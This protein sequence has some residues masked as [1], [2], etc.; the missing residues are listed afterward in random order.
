MIA[1]AQR[2]DFVRAGVAARGQNGGFI[3]FGAAVGEEALGQLAA[4]SDAGDALGQ[5]GL[6]LIGEH[7]R[8]V[9]QL[10]DL[11][12]NLSIHRL[13]AMAD[14]DGDD[15]AEEIQILIAVGVPDELILGVRDDQRLLDS[16]GRRWETDIAGWRE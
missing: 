12:V 4:R 10:V 3:G 9:L 6:R 13:V 14:A 8:D 5:R 16:S 1:V 2:D 15:A 7:G 11:L